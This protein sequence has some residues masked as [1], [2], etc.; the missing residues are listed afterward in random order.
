MASAPLLLDL[1]RDFQVSEKQ[2]SDRL[3]RRCERFTMMGMKDWTW[4]NWNYLTWRLCNHWEMSP[5]GN[6]RRQAPRPRRTSPGRAH[7]RCDLWA[8]HQVVEPGGHEVF[9]HR[10]RPPGGHGPERQAAG[11]AL[12]GV[13]VHRAAAAMA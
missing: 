13:D 2:K 6:P 4:I 9:E 7:H 11:H 5:G 1:L 8:Q 3:R 12:H 10:P